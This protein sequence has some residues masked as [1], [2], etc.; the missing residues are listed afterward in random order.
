ML[1]QL[2]LLNLLEKIMYNTK[3]H[4]ILTALQLPV[5]DDNQY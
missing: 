5:D 3:L 2:T 1:T 4:L